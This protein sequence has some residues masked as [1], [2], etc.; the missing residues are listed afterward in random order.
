M[1]WA[2]II[3]AVLGAAASIYSSKQAKKAA[4]PSKGQ[5]LLETQL[6]DN[7]RETSPMALELLRKSAAGYDSTEQY[8]RRLQQGDRNSV[9]SL[10]APA[11]QQQDEMQRAAALSS[12]QLGGQGGGSA[13][14]RLGLL[15]SIQRGRND[16]ILG[17]QSQA[18]QM[19]SALASERANLGSS[20]FGQQASGTQGLAA[21][22]LQRNSFGYGASR[23]AG[24]GLFE[25]MR[26]LAP[27]MQ[28]WSSG[29]RST[30]GQP[31]GSLPTYSN[32]FGNAMQFS[33]GVR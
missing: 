14:G 17:L 23:D 21:L 20:L 1:P 8:W 6:A 31:N 32:S 25:I 7:L 18:P 29:Q 4:K 2:A 22:G 9:L 19:L 27:Y 13:E 10:L 28:N 26:Y 12:L 16:A 15:D 5:Q 30:P 3:P 24:A 11:I 33:Q